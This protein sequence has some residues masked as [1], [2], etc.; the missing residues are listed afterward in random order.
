M[1]LVP[2]S[3]VPFYAEYLMYIFNVMRIIIKVVLNGNL[4]CFCILFRNC[5]NRFSE[6]VDMFKIVCGVE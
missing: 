4:C 6:Y 3:N 5:E 1:K 2:L